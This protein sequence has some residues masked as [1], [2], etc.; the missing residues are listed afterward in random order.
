MTDN[1]GQRTRHTP[2]PVVPFFQPAVA[3]PE[4]TRV[5]HKKGRRG[6]GQ[7]GKIMARGEPALLGTSFCPGSSI[8]VSA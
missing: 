2:G 5:A 4:T 6:A 1:M 3:R 8:T 7:L